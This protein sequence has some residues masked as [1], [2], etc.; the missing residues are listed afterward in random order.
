MAAEPA[1]RGAAA[2]QVPAGAAPDLDEKLLRL[3]AVGG[4]AGVTTLVLREQAS[5]SWLLGGRS[6][7]PQTLDSSCLDVVVHLDGARP[8]LTVLTN[9]IEAPRLRDTE[10]AGL[11]ADWDVVPWWQPRDTRLPAGPGVAADRPYGDVLSVAGP[12]A[13]TRRSL[14]AHQVSLLEDL[15]RDTAAAA[16]AVAQRVSPHMSEYAVAAL[17]GAELLQRAAD[18]VVLMVAGDDRI[19]PHRHPLPTSRPV[20]RRVMVVCC[21]RRHGLVASLT[22][23][24]VMGRLGTAEH[25]AYH[26]LLGVEQAFLD[27]TTAGARIGD[28]VA[29]GTA[30]YA[31]YGFDAL[32]WHRHHQG[33]FSGWVPR[34]YPAHAGSDDVVPASSV[35]AWNPSGQGWKVEDTCLVGAGGARPLVADQEWP[36]TT[37]GGRPRPDVLVL[38]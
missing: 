15:C 28:V 16:T 22:R 12:V 27:A 2:A 9:A 10:L 33:G 17:L 37:V 7:V 36:T 21:A 25:D 1:G 11:D 13:T 24:V 30:A 3:R 29:D 14:T 19:G 32:E 38:S 31:T 5:L 18:P 26:R 4:D 35:V 23:T 6:H 20:G 34:E 8:R